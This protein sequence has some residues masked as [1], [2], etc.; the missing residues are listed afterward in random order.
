VAGPGGTAVCLVVISHSQS[1]PK[2]PK[3]TL[4]PAEQTAK[5][6]E[7]FTINVKVD[8]DVKD[9]VVSDKT[10]DKNQRSFSFS[11]TESRAITVSVAG[12][13]GQST[14]SAAINIKG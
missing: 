4:E 6:G 14:C 3:C 9:L 2:P 7:V 1:L 13:G 5:A 11:L 10:E 12:E 8:G